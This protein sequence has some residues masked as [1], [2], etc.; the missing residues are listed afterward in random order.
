MMRDPLSGFPDPVL[1]RDVRSPIQS[2]EETAPPLGPS[3]SYR[4]KT[5]SGLGSFRSDGGGLTPVIGIS[6][7]DGGNTTSR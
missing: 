3:Q 2:K 6:Q 4:G 7:P 1:L 5:A